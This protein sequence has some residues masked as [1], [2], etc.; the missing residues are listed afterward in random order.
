MKHSSRIQLFAGLILGA[1]IAGI[2]GCEGR[3]EDKAARID[4]IVQRYIDEGQV[5][6]VVLVADKRQVIYRR[7]AGLAHA[8]WNVPNTIDARFHLY[9]I[10]KSF[11]AMLIMQLLEEGQIDLQSPIAT[12]LPGY[13]PDVGEQVTIHH[14]LIH[15][16]GIPDIQYSKLPLLI[17]L[18]AVE[19]LNTYAAQDLE[20]EPGSSQSYSA[21]T[22]YS[23]LGAII[24][25][26]TGQPYVEVL[27]ER[28]LE[29]LGMSNTGFIYP[30]HAIPNLTTSY[31]NTLDERR[32]RFLN[33][34]CNGASS[35]YSTAGDLY[36]W[37]QALRTHELLTPA[38]S[39]VMLTPYAP[40]DQPHACYGWSYARYPFGGVEKDLYA[41][42]GGGRNI[43][44]RIPEDGYLVVILNNV[45]SS[46]L[47]QMCVEI[48]NV[49]YGAE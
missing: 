48:L 17:D 31:L 19:F 25:A 42:E 28:I 49:L 13:R 44:M 10:T 37:D 38:L 47:A 11:T 20:F 36:R 15:T 1:S 39:Q 22:G 41:S 16:H 30:G 3:G 26:V 45:R 34:S 18:P 33:H 35:L 24:E 23:I 21:L 5:N 46:T 32:L 40:A 29:P 12:Y 27:E 2:I 6:G 7:A 4:E 43:L 9:S 8:E 14:L